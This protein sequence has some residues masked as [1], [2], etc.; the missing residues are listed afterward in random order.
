MQKTKG[1]L[2]EPSQE[3]K[4]KTFLQPQHERRSKWQQKSF[5]KN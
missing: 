3:N 5:G 2:Y 1:F 4:T